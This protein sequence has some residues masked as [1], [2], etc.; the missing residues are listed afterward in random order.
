PCPTSVHTEETLCAPP[1]RRTY[2]EEL[3]SHY[4]NEWP[5]TA[6][7]YS[8]W[9]SDDGGS[10]LDRLEECRSLAWFA[11]HLTDHTV[12]VLSSACHLRWCPCCAQARAN[13]LS[14]SVADWYSTCKS[15]KL[16][17]LTL[18]HTDEPLEDQLD[19]LYEAF[20]KLLRCKYMRARVRGWI[21]FFQVKWIHE[22]DGWHPHIHALLDADYIPKVEISTRWAKYTQGSYIVN[23]KACWSAES[24]ANHVSRYATRPGTLSS[25]PP[26]RRLQLMQALHGRRIVGACRSAKS[27]SLS[28]PKATDKD[29][30]RTLGSY[31]QV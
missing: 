14:H 15:A 16:L 31:E 20:G 5:A 25:V 26:D 24:A 29:Q 4:P 27:V 11:I 17:T 19:H 21:W 3:R 1:P 2:G 30:W 28:P 18:R 13:Y 22:T 23:I 12:T 7:A 10:R 9:D 8:A 6:D